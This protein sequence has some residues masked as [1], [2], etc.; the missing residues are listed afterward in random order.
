[1]IRHSSVLAVGIVGLVLLGL[2][3]CATPSEVP[4]PPPAASIELGALGFTIFDA[5]GETIASHEFSGD[6]EPAI[7]SITDAF[8]FE[9]LL[10]EVAPD[11]ELCSPA[12]LRA[13]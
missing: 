8:G 7:A 6:P 2:T 1:M 9:P 12:V 13:T 3:G 10:S 5:D 4:P 11:P